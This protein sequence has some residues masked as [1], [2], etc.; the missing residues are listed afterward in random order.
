MTLRTEPFVINTQIIIFRIIEYWCYHSFHVS[1]ATV[2]IAANGTVLWPVLEVFY[3]ILTDL[4]IDLFIYWCL[5]PTWTVFQLYHGIISSAGKIKYIPNILT[6]YVWTYLLQLYNL[7]WCKYCN[8]I[9][10]ST[11]SNIGYTW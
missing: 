10:W 1:M 5:T 4:L 3:L 11:W 9:G 7:I 6:A 8:L 2:Y